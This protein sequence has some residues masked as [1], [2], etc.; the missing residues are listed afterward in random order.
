MKNES[1]K[2]CQTHYIQ[3]NVGLFTVFTTTAFA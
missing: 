2:I 3:Q 1:D